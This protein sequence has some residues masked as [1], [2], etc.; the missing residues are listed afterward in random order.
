MATQRVISAAKAMRLRGKCG[1][2]YLVRCIVLRLRFTP[3][4][5]SPSKSELHIPV[6]LSGPLHMVWKLFPLP[7]SF[8]GRQSR[9]GGK[10]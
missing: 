8:Y 6:I 7:R 4:L 3:Y 9:P 5:G 2:Q 1:H 10:S